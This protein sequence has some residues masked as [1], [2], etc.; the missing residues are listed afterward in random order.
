[1]LDGDLVQA[2]SATRHALSKE[3]E[4]VGSLEGDEA[5]S[6]AVEKLLGDPRTDPGVDVRSVRQATQAVRLLPNP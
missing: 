2:E 5:L 6:A 3:W 1:M 4:I